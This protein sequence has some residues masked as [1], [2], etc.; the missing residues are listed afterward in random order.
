[1]CSVQQVLGENEGYCRLKQLTY[2]Q[3]VNIPA[4]NDPSSIAVQLHPLRE[5]EPMV[6][7]WQTTMLPLSNFMFIAQLR[8]MTPPVVPMMSL[9]A[10]HGDL[11]PVHHCRLLLQN[12]VQCSS[13]PLWSQ[14]ACLLLNP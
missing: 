4:A 5:P 3:G 2:G 8:R 11:L 7:P 9:L 10:D 14:A 1:M 6:H 13:L 12:S